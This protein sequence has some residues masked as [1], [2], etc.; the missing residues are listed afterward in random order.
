MPEVSSA[1]SPTTGGKVRVEHAVWTAERGWT[2]R[3]EARAANA[4]WVLY[5]AAPGLMDDPARLAE[6]RARYPSARITGCTTGGE[7]VDDETLDQSLVVAAV[8]LERTRIRASEELEVSLETSF[9]VGQRL[10]TSLAAEDL[11]ALFV[12]SDGT[13]TN[14]SDL[15]RGLRSAVAPGVV[16][17][18]GLAGDGPRFG[19]TQVGLDSAPTSARAV[20]VGLYGRHLRVGH[21]SVGGWRRFGPERLITRAEG[22]VLYEL[23]GKSAL[24]LYKQYLGE[25]AAG[26]P[27][28]ALLYPLAIRRKD[29]PA[30][31][32]VRT[33][34]DVDHASKGLVFAGDMPEGSVAQLM[35]GMFDELVTGASE[36]AAN[37]GTGQLAILVSCIG[38]KLLMGQ[39]ISDEVEAVGDVLGA[40]CAR[41][42]Y[43]SYGEISPHQVS[44]VADLHN[45]T[46]TITTFAEDLR[47]ADD[48]E[49]S[50]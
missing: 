36:A 40:G 16:L 20:A 18:G 37:A 33:I 9:A 50:A 39:R 15:V 13:R 35:R 6:L 44:G 17:T 19:M 42:G 49:W 41:I 27:G 11:Q 1:L 43:Y 14:G 47:T 5:F 34:V 23:D 26:L 24:D 7:I 32:L 25:E 10:G 4:T 48:A 28:T 31:E 45:Q 46:M 8:E 30:T 3:S 12:L 21:G 38:R 29:S 22:N 2:Q